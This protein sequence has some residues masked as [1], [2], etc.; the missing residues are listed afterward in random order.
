MLHVVQQRLVV[1][2]EL[3]QEAEVLTVDL[4]LTAV[5]LPHRE[6]DRDARKVKVG[7]DRP[8]AVDLVA[9]RVGNLALVLLG[10]INRLI[11][12]YPKKSKHS[13]YA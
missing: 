2:E 11:L 4:L 12:E 8:V 10:E 13:P 7:N 6:E 1:D 9:R 5:H 3:P